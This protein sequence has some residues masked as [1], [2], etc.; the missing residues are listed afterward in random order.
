M[1]ALPNRPSTR[2]NLAET[3][4]PH[5]DGRTTVIRE[6]RR[7]ESVDWSFHDV[8]HG[9]VDARLIFDLRWGPRSS[10]SGVRRAGT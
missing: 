1:R 4:E 3:F 9:T 8:E 7:L 5:A 10:T 2:V 6:S